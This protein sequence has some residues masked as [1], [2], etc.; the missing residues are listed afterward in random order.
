MSS[1]VHHELLA[2]GIH[3]SRIRSPL[4]QPALAVTQET[5]A[6]NEPDAPPLPIFEEIGAAGTFV[7]RTVYKAIFAS[8]TVPPSA[9]LSELTKVDDVYVD[10]R[11]AFGLSPIRCASLKRRTMAD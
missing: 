5:L 10:W 6:R 7:E 9:E 4:H 11:E 8:G 3:T 1:T 2:C